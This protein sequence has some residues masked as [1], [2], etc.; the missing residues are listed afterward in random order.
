MPEIRR[1]KGRLIRIVLLRF[2]DCRALCGDWPSG[3]WPFRLLVPHARLFIW[4]WRSAAC[5]S[6][7]SYCNKQNNPNAQTATHVPTCRRKRC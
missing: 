1:Q 5:E 6:T 7:D 4:Q 2:T 3:K